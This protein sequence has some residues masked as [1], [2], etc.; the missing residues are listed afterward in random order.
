MQL[1]GTRQRHI[2]TADN[3][4]FILRPVNRLEAVEGSSHAQPLRMAEHASH[5]ERHALP[6][7]IQI[8]RLKWIG[9][10]AVSSAGSV[11]SK[12]ESCRAGRLEIDYTAKSVF[13]V[14]AARQQKKHVL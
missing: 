4:V 5:P 2:I 10:L 7:R 13:P 6:N 11:V 1:Q 8:V 9:L 12:F 3:S 14:L